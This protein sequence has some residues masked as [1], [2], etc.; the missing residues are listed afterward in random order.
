VAPEDLDLSGSWILN[1]E[2]SDNPRE[3]MQQGEMGGGGRPAGDGMR[4][5]TGGMGGRPGGRGGAGGEDER[6]GMLQ[7]MR[8]ATEPPRRI[9]IEQGDST[10]TIRDE[11][12][13]ALTLRY[14]W[15]KVTLETENGG[16]IDARAR[17]QG[18]ELHVEQEVHQG[19]K[20]LQKYSL[21]SYG[22][23]LHVETHVDTRRGPQELA[24]HYV[25]DAA[26]RGR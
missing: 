22:D 6:R 24:F 21:S 26:N 19:G 14:S 2:Q 3:M 23:Q 15:Q 18:K 5:P 17:W 8:I 1:L 9:V 4:P 16:G 20:I 12:G 11:N 13:R 10:V 7:T 25:Y